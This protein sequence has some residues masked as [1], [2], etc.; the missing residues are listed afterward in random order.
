M[1][2]LQELPT[3]KFLFP[4]LSFSVLSDKTANILKLILAYLKRLKHDTIMIITIQRL[5]FLLRKAAQRANRYTETTNNTNYDKLKQERPA[6]A[7][8]PARRLRNYCTV[9]VRAVGL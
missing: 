9:Y 4:L 3:L 1:T 2:T 5:I 8:K 6:V 7:D